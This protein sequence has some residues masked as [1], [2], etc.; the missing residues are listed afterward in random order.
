LHPGSFR[1]L[2]IGEFVSIWGFVETSRGNSNFVLSFHGI[3]ASLAFS[4][5]LGVIV[6]A[7]GILD[8]VSAGL[9]RN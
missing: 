7:L 9:E 3:F 5:L 4:V 1:L 6:V 8:G 2:S